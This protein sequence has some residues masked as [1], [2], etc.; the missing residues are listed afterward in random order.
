[1]N[2]SRLFSSVLE[3]RTA[4]AALLLR[5]LL[6]PIR[7]EGVRAEVGRPFYGAIST[8]DVLAVIDDDAEENSPEPV[9]MFCESGGGGN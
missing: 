6:G 4:I 8:L 5:C 1:M 7:M 9:W 3:R 2:A